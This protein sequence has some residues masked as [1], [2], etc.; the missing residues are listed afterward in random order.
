[1]FRDL[2]H[3]SIILGFQGRLIGRLRKPFSAVL[4]GRTKPIPDPFTPGAKQQTHDETH[5]EISWK[6]A[7]FSE[8]SEF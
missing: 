1:M 6:K 7:I 4:L 2:L 5:R 8:I 3:P